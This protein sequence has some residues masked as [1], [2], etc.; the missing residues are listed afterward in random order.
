VE[1]VVANSDILSRQLLGE[2]E[3]NYKNVVKRSG[4]KDKIQNRRPGT[5]GEK[6]AGNLIA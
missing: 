6:K 5:K 1:V 2:N 3:E 4:F